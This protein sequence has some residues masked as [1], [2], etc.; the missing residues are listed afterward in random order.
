MPTN[1]YGKDLQA[2]CHDPVTGFFRDGFC[3]TG[4]GDIGLHTVCAR[5][6][7]EFLEFSKMRGND[8]TTPRPE[9][10]FPGLKAGDFWCLC[11]QRWAEAFQAGKAPPVKLDASHL[12]VLEFLDLE[13]LKDCSI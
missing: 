11:V 1:V 6:T 10:Q 7:D 12:S 4:S 13:T 5:M 2:C 3:R 9:Y 8:L